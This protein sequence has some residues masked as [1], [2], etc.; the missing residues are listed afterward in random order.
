MASRRT[1][2]YRNAEW[3][4][5]E[6][7]RMRLAKMRMTSLEGIPQIKQV[8]GKDIG[9]FICRQQQ[10]GPSQPREKSLCLLVFAL[11]GR[12]LVQ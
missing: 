7:A 12:S 6:P 11:V 2:G 3:K 8:C 4:L 5:G 10:C 9:G 1:V